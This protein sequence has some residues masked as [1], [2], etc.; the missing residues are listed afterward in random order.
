MV[1]PSPHQLQDHQNLLS[2]VHIQFQAW[3]SAAANIESECD[4]CVEKMVKVKV[5]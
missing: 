5:C 4:L 3:V 2:D 1:A